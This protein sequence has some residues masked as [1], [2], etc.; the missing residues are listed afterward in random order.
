MGDVHQLI[1]GQ[2]KQAAL[3]AGRDTR[4]VAAAASYLADEAGGVGFLYSGWCQ[5][6]LP[7]KRL[8]DGQD[9]QVKS[10]H[11]TLIVE[12]GVRPGPG[13]L[14][15]PVGV[16][17]GSR[18]RLI[19]IYLQTEAL[20][21]GCREVEL[22][23]SLRE[24]LQRLGIP[25]GGKSIKEVREQAERISRCRLTFHVQQ[26]KRVGLVNQQIVDGTLF[27]EADEPRQ[28]KL[29]VDKAKLSE[30]FFDQLKRHPMPLE[31]AAIRAISN[32]SMALDIYAWLAY[33]LH[34]LP[35]SRPIT[36]AA[37]K[38]QFGQGFGA[39]RDFKRSF[40]DNLKLALAV[41]PAARVD[42]DEGGLVLHPSAP[43]VTPRQVTAQA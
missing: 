25:Q 15:I 35:S 39:M 30:A 14:P 29:F 22:G 23:R 11:I 8:P 37:L 12:A 41:Y 19:L 1:T 26:G 7:H 36:W 17:Y 33:R 20:R 24:W 2:G 40:L 5:A 10:E 38:S 42:V 43:P 32:N 9:W 27:I 18:A 31:E 21:T 4:E 3:K 16:P 6:A 28:S 13:D 34:A